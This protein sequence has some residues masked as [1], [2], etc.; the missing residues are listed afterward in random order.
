[1]VATVAA[2]VAAT[3]KGR[4]RILFEIL[5]ENYLAGEFRMGEKE[6]CSNLNL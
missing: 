2:T 3:Q 1:M 4:E 5:A 6:V